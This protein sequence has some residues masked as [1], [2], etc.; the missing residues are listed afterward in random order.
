MIDNCSNDDIY[1]YEFNETCYPEKINEI[2]QICNI[3][4]LL[5]GIIIKDENILYQII[6][7]TN[8]KN[9]IRDNISTIY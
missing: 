8:K 6:P 4:E 3:T 9:S 2:I 7:M 1:N 5:K